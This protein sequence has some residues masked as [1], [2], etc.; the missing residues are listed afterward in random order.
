[1]IVPSRPMKIVAGH[2]LRLTACGTFSHIC[3]SDP[4]YL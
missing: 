4:S 2:V 3:L 1:L